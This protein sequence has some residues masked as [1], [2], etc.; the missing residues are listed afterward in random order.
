MAQA[1]VKLTVDGSQATR[2]LQG[3]QNKTTNDNWHHIIFSDLIT[4]IFEKDFSVEVIDK[5]FSTSNKK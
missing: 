3:V 4:K 1:N 5:K 2:A